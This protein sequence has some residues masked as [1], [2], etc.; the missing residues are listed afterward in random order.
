MGLGS[1]F[2]HSLWDHLTTS[3]WISCGW[4]KPQNS[5]YVYVVVQEHCYS[6]VE[7]L[8]CLW[9]N[10]PGLQFQA[11]LTWS[12]TVKSLWRMDEPKVPERCKWCVGV[13]LRDGG[14]SANQLLEHAAHVRMARHISEVIAATVV[15]YCRFGG[16]RARFEEERTEHRLSQM[17]RCGTVESLNPFLLQ[18]CCELSFFSLGAGLQW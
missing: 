9:M 12:R 4:T 6:C 11:C 18:P 8:Q 15:Y 10:Y 17:V 1:V 13:A 5:Y 7:Q 16:G 14:S 3:L 2:G